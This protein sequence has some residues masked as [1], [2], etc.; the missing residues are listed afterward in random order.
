MNAFII[1]PET[2]QFAKEKMI[3]MH[4]CGLAKSASVDTDPRQHP[5][6]EYGLY[7]HMALLAMVL[8]KA[9]GI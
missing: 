3:V 9:R 8:G 2:M 5:A 7:V 1:T 4:P 6:M